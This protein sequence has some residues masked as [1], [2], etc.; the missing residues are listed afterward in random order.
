MLT[1][2]EADLPLLGEHDLDALHCRILTSGTSGSPRAV[3][4]TYGNHLWSAVG[5]AFN[6]G[7]RPRRPLALLPAAAPRRRACRSSCAR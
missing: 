6:L 3:G 5:S 1:M 7:R 2:S 4:L